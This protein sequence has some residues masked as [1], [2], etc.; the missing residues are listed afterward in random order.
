M[1]QKSLQF[2]KE[3]EKAAVGYLKK[4]GYRILEK[5]FRNA[6]GEIDI[7]AEHKKVVVFIEVKTRA[8]HEF[9]APITAI[10]FAK[11]KKL[12]KMARS[13]L[14]EKHI[15]DRECRFDV[16]SITGPPD[17]PKQ[18]VIELTQDAFREV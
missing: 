13:F 10:T 14:A 18:W 11:Q 4:N 17:Q 3:G 15:A 16:V 8:D 6:I 7:I 1:T 12:S 2:G 9:G 5:N